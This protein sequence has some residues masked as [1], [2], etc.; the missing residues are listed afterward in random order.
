[1]RTDY[2]VT[3][4]A[5]LAHEHRLGIFRYLV[6]A[7]PKGVP[8][9]ELADHL[10]ISATNLSFHLKALDHA[11][12]IT[13]VRDGRNILYGVNVTRM[14]GLMA[15]LTE[16]CCRGRPELCGIASKTKIGCK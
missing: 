4:L 15:Y 2:A 7:I 6:R 3:A 5:A 8:A 13:S 1:M 11:Q 10:G 14:N 9:G 16:D 12:L